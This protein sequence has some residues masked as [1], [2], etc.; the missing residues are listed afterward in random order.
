VII[1]KPYAFLIKH[2]RMIHLVL[3][4]FVF[5][6]ITKTSGMFKFFND[7]VKNGYYTYS[8]DLGYINFYMF[9]AIILILL[10]AAFVYLLMRWKKKSRIFYMSICVFYFIL[11]VGFLVYFNIFNT[12][13]NTV[14]DVRTVRAYRDIVALMYFPQYFFLIFSVIRAIGFDLKKFDFKKDLEELDIAEEDQ[15]EIEV[16]FGQNTYKYKRKARRILREIK[17]YALENKFFFGVICGCLTLV[18]GFF[19]YLN[20]SV[21][22]KKYDESEFFSVNGV[23]FRVMD[24]YVSSVDLGGKVIN[25]NKKYVA[26]KVSMENTNNVR[27]NLATD[28]LRLMLDD[29]YYFPIYSKGDYFKDLGE[30]YYKTNTLYPGEFYEYLLVF[31]IPVDKKINKAVFRMIDDV[32]I[33]RG[34]IA[35][36]YKDVSLDVESF[37]DIL[38]PETYY[39]GDAISLEESTLHSSELV[40]NSYTIGD[41]FTETYDYCVGST[42]NTGKVIIT[43]DVLGRYERT[44]LKLDM[45]LDLDPLLYINKYITN[46]SDFISFFG[47]I[48]YEIND[49]EVNAPIT[50]KTYENLETKNVYLEV[51]SEI[52][53]AKNIKLK[54]FIRNKRYIINLK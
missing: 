43:P 41:N 13:L 21:F 33:L 51:P 30:G 35:A 31:E 12:I 6:L 52:K 40:I 1:R 9:I 8:N 5:Y 27:M 24:S 50:V 4:I 44:I 15:E 25:D 22:T 20:L 14:L 46:N 3:S 36:K 47:N 39:Y 2:F 19:I 37:M 23:V 28:S 11:F 48:S 16:T 54:V 42:C 53:N 17:Y 26:I 45:E 10:L 49:K 7:Y 29:E 18:I 32:D 34:E 38:E